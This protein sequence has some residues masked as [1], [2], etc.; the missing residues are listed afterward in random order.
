[1]D[2]SDLSD[3][4]KDLA[5]SLFT[6]P[7]PPGPDYVMAGDVALAYSQLSNDRLELHFAVRPGFKPAKWFVVG[8]LAYEAEMELFKGMR[9]MRKMID[10]DDDDSA[11]PF[12]VSV[13]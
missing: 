8:S 5:K 11:E 7:L 9:K 13:Y 12:Y 6:E 10:N 2:P 1:M 4:Q 3:E